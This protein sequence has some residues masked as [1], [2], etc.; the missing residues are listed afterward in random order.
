MQF[1]SNGPRV[2]SSGWSWRTAEGGIAAPG[3]WLLDLPVRDDGERHGLNSQQFSYKAVSSR[4]LFT[5]VLAKE[6]CPVPSRLHWTVIK[7][8]VLWKI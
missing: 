5:F 8:S 4:H 1:F 7:V 2:Q 3:R 6:F